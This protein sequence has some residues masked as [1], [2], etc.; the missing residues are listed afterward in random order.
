MLYDTSIIRP[1]MRID[2]FKLRGK[3]VANDRLKAVKKGLLTLHPDFPD[4][5]LQRK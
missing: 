4:K 2:D 1:E 3:D 5:K